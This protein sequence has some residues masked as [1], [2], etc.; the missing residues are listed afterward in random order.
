MLYIIIRGY[1]ENKRPQAYILFI[2]ITAL[3]LV[4]SARAGNLKETGNK[5]LQYNHTAVSALDSEIAKNSGKKRPLA[6]LKGLRWCVIFCDNDENFNQTFSN[7]ITMLDELRLHS[8]D[9]FL[10]R[11]VHDLI[12]NEFRRAEPRLGKLFA[13]DPDGY[14][15]F[16]SIMPI[17]YHHGIPVAPYKQFAVKYFA[18]IK[19]PDRLAEFR[20]AACK[21]D[22]D[23]LTDLVVG[24]AFNDMA[25][26][27]KVDRDFTL[28]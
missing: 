9:P 28:P 19:M 14:D 16:I 2:I 23:A 11:I 3:I 6:V 1:M 27:W 4:P 26:R 25:Y 24:A 8:S 5:P 7:Y 13:A 10:T 20:A 17:A 12:L 18:G 15:D 21:R 22:Y